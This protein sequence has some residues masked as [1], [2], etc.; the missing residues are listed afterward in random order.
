[1]LQTVGS[2]HTGGTARLQE[3][4]IYDLNVIH[5]F[6]LKHTNADALSR[7]PYTSCLNQHTHNDAQNID[8]DSKEKALP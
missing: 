7:V 4:G 5:R 1:M 2:K 8:E 6:V 3:L